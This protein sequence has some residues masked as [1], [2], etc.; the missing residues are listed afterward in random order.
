MKRSLVAVTVILG[1]VGC[2]DNLAPATDAGSPDAP[3]GFVTAP[4]TALPLL[5]PH[6]GVLLD[7]VQLVTITY[8]GY[9]DRAGVEAFGDAIV[10]SPW[11]ATVGTEYGVGAGTHVAKVHATAP[12]RLQDYTAVETEMQRLLT[13]HVVPTPPATGSQLFYILYIPPSLPLGPELRDCCYGYHQMIVDSGTGRRVPF[14]IIFDD[15]TGLD[16]TTTTASHELIEGTTDPYE[17][18]DDGWY[19]DPPLPDPW[20]LLFEENA[21]LC[22]FEPMEREGAFAVQ[23]NWSMV[24]AAAGRAP[25][26]PHQGDDEWYDVSAQPATMPTVAKGS[27]VMFTLTGWSTKAVADWELRLYDGDYSELSMAQLQPALSATHINNGQTVTLT[28]HVPASAVSGK[29]SGL[30]VLSGP[31]ERPWAVGFIVQ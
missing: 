31:S 21:D 18:P 5:S 10:A 14:A 24:E 22:S 11:Y 30:Y 15:G 8:D 13:D 16:T 4:H 2:G 23:R 26:V 19:V 1:M 6:H 28:M 9:A 7:H 20:W 17:T 25:C 29:A 12:A 27:T 3:A